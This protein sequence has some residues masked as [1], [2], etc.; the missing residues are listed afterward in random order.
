MKKLSFLVAAVL[1][2]SSIAAGRKPPKRPH[3]LGIAGVS[4]YVSDVDAAHRFYRTLIDPEH[5]C[6]YCEN[7]PSRYLFLP[8][9]Q[10]L[11]FLKMPSPAPA[12]LLANIS[13]LTE[14]I[15]G[16]RRYLKYKKIDFNI[17][18]KKHTHDLVRIVLHDPEGHEISFTDAYNLAN[19]EDLNAGI[20]PARPANPVRIIHAG[21]VVNNRDAIDR[22]YKDVLGF[23]PYW[24]GGM[25]D[26][27]KD[28]WVA[29]QVPDGTDWVE[30]ML[31][32]SPN[33]DKHTLGVMN[34]IAL[35]V[36][37]IHAIQKRIIQAGI[38]PNEEPK[39]GRDGKWQLN[40]YDADDTRIEFMEFK[41]VEKPCCSEFTGP[42]PSPNGSN[43]PQ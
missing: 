6:D 8:S 34:H 36:T 16:F 29:M 12:D 28:D 11:T 19:A 1:L 23:K 5:V 35:G 41:P 32:I 24:H 31:R 14:D 27:G 37:D 20:A 13:F 30:Y 25:K 21:F 17:V 4:I 7:V 9:G 3:I 18:E 10:R 2:C 22:F 38:K 43:V 39:I 42:H 33:A 26:D 40:L 15:D